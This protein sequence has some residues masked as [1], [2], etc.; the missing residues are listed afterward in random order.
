LGD[1]LVLGSCG[2]HLLTAC[3]TSHVVLPQDAIRPQ[4]GDVVWQEGGSRLA[5]HVRLDGLVAQLFDV[6]E[7]KVLVQFFECLNLVQP[8][9][10]DRV[11]YLVFLINQGFKYT[12]ITISCHSGKLGVKARYE[13]GCDDGSRLLI[14]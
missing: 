1:D 14:A 12:E 7:L 6:T 4:D 5:I 9:H 3:G 8:C 13:F 2:N 11:R 10:L